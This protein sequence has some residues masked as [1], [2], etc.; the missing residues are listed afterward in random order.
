MRRG[1]SHH[2]GAHQYQRECTA[3]VW[4]AQAKSTCCRRWHAAHDRGLLAG[5]VDG[6][7]VVVPHGD[8]EYYLARPGIAV[9]RPGL[10][11]GAIDLTGYFGLHPALRSLHPYWEAGQLGF[12]HASGSPDGSRSHFEAQ[13][14]MESGTPGQHNT[15]D[16][17]M[18]RLLGY[19]PVSDSPVQALTSV[20]RCH[21]S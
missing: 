9:A 6:L 5:A 4:L 2:I 7:N 8:R 20:K 17:W 13:D 14:Y 11:N 21:A 16:G 19:L 12:V 1:T 15:R 18:N 3:G 10:P